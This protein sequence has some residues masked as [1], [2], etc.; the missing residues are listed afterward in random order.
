MLAQRA[1]GP[2]EIS[3]GPPQISLARR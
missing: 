1:E 3:I 2:P